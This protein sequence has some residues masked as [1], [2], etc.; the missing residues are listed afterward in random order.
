M[1]KHELVER[2]NNENRYLVTINYL[3]NNMMKTTTFSNNFPIMDL[4]TARFEASKTILDCFEKE[5]SKIKKQQELEKEV[6]G[7]IE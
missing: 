4:E 5:M 3:E 7:L 2:L 1:I 6:K